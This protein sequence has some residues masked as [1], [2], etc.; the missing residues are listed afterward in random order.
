MPISPIPNPRNLIS[1][2]LHYQAVIDIPNSMTFTEDLVKACSWAID[3][4]KTGIFNLASAQALSAYSIMSIYKK[5]N[6]NHKFSLMTESQ[7][8]R[9]VLAKRSNCILNCEKIKQNGFNFSNLNINN[10]IKE[11]YDIQLY[12]TTNMVKG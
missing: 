8:D 5:Y 11:F 9:A 12:L 10:I 6:N 7:L 3:N 1:K 4:K 2:L